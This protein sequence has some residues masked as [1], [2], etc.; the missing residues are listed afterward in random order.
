MTPT[1]S[2]PT[3][4]HQSETG[5]PFHRPADGTW[6]KQALTLLIGDFLFEL[7][8][9]YQELTLD[10]SIISPLTEAREHLRSV[11]RSNTAPPVKKKKNPAKLPSRPFD[12]RVPERLRPPAIPP[13]WHGQAIT[14]TGIAIVRPTH[15]DEPN[16]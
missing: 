1:P 15:D 7:E 14:G 16:F 5:I 4:T 6:T 8:N 2:Q 11:Y 13:D 10:Y 9:V 12:F 3:P